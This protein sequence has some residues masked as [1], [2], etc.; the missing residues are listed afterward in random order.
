VLEKWKFICSI[1]SRNIVSFP[2]FFLAR[3]VAELMMPPNVRTVLVPIPSRDP[4]SLLLSQCS[5]E[6]GSGA[7]QRE[8]ICVR[9]S[10][11]TFEVLDPSECS[12]LER[13]PSQQPCHLKP[14]GA[15][16]FSTEWSM[17]R[18]RA[19]H[20]ECLSVLRLRAS[21]RHLCAR[22]WPQPESGLQIT[23][24]VPS[25]QGCPLGRNLT[26]A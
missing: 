11:D 16:W 24:S 17:V 12:F 18:H 4:V 20:R 5:I 15:K 9:K 6:C 10:A 25:L 8:V 13:P 22:P 19:I 1:S 21:H 3:L 23:L 7:Q 2:G 14:C 26:F